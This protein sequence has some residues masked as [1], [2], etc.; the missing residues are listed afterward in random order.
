MIIASSILCGV[1]L[2]SAQSQR[3]DVVSITPCPPVTVTEASE[4][5]QIRMGAIRPVG[6]RLE[7]TR[8]V[9]MCATVE[10]LIHLA[11]NG[12]YYGHQNAAGRDVRGGP[13]WIRSERYTIEGS[14]AG[15]EYPDLTGAMLRSLLEDQ[16]QLRV[17]RHTDDAPMYGL[18]VAPGGLKITP[19]A[20]SDCLTSTGTL[21]SATL[22][23]AAARVPCGTSMAKLN[24]T[25]RISDMVPATMTAIAKLFDLDRLVIDQTGV[26]DRFVVHFEHETE[27]SGPPVAALVTELEQQLGL[28]LVSTK[29]K[30]SWV[31][32]ERI[33]KP[34]LR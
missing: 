26:K 29:G 22:Q 3:F 32:I 25:V 4:S 13:S 31:Q 33:E 7:R 18:K 9:A 10:G 16:F 24:G 6:L 14:V 17:R 12:G 34:S 11:Y 30:R 28:T 27:P 5:G 19:I 20:A 21:P 23:V 15:V 8:M 2:P 1:A